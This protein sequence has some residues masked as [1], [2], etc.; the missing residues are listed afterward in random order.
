MTENL[1][2][3]HDRVVSYYLHHYNVIGLAADLFSEAWHLYHFYHLI[4]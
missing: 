4:G 2:H 1:H 3:Y